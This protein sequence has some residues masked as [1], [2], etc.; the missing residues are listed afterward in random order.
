MLNE[1]KHTQ[2]EL[3]TNTHRTHLS[4]PHSDNGKANPSPNTTVSSRT[5]ADLVSLASLINAIDN[6]KDET[7]DNSKVNAI[8]DNSK[9]ETHA[10]APKIKT[11]TA[12]KTF[13]PIPFDYLYL[14]TGILSATE[15]VLEKL[16]KLTSEFP[17]RSA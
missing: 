8:D 1:K 11:L 16:Q 12:V 10:R 14:G 6:S 15:H 3:N 4:P 5:E 9:D 17:A 7:H 13:N 2:S